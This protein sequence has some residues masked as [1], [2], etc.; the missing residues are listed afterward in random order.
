MKNAAMVSLLRHA[1][2][3]LAEVAGREKQLFAYQHPA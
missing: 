2:S 1:I 3:G